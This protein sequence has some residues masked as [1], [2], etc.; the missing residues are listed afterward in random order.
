MWSSR[1]I[2]RGI[3]NCMT[4]SHVT[5]VSIPN[6][7]ALVPSV[8]LY[9][10]NGAWGGSIGAAVEGFTEIGK[11]KMLGLNDNVGEVVGF[12]LGARVPQ[13]SSVGEF[14][15][16]AATSS[17]EVDVRARIA[18]M[19]IGNRCLWRRGVLAGSSADE[20]ASCPQRSSN[21]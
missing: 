2:L 21:V 12:G 14:V 17:S 20:I 11:D 8:G 3:K 9:V 13:I 7:G 10:G 5:H 18:F 16:I 4:N 1:N 15:A 6:V 19:S